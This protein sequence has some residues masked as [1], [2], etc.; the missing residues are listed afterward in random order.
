LPQYARDLGYPRFLVRFPKQ[1][2]AT[3]LAY[4][5]TAIQENAKARVGV[6]QEMRW[7]RLS[8]VVSVSVNAGII[9]FGAPNK[10]IAMAWTNPMWKI[11]I[12]NIAN[13]ANK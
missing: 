8:K 10:E 12:R 5:T 13:V 3:D 1:D 4:E 11:P 2:P 6:L 9:T 7:C